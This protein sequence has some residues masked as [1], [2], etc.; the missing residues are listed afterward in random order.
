[1][2]SLSRSAALRSRL[3]EVGLSRAAI[4]AAWPQWW[5]EEAETSESASAELRFTLARR[6]GLDP[7][8]LIA[9]TGPAQFLWSQEGRFKHLTNEDELERAAIVSFGRS[10]AAI[11]SAIAPKAAFDLVGL[12]ASQLR[13]EVLSKDRPYVDLGDLL[14]IAWSAGVPVLHLRVFPLERKRMAAMAVQ[15]PTGSAVL[16]GKDASYPGPIAFYIA[17][18]LGHIALGH[19]KREAPIVD[20]DQDQPTLDSSDTEEVAADTYALELLTGRPR[21]VVLA[22]GGVVPSGRELARVVQSAGLTLQIEP[23]VFA[24]CYGFNTGEWAVVNAAMPHIYG[25]PRP[26]WA[27]INELARAQLAISDASPDTAD[28]LASVLGFAAE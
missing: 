2:T 17:H 9:S 12:G 7:R 23:G 14:A 4:D 20:I 19:V 10:I 28:F 13:A 27:A 25:T 11:L 3:R 21:P 6:L 8:S 22:E 5:S 15:T 16:V 18:E 1:M 24:Q 26:A